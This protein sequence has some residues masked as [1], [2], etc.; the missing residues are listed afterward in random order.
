MRNSKIIKIK[1]GLY[2][3]RDNLEY[4]LTAKDCDDVIELNPK[5]ISLFRYAPAAS[6]DVERSSLNTSQFLVMNE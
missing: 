5:E 4:I 1:S 3:N 2:S 6:C